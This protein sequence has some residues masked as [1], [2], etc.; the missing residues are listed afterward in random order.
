MCKLKQSCSLS[1]SYPR[2]GCV[3]KDKIDREIG[4]HVENSRL[5]HAIQLNEEEKKAEV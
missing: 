1:N 5:R 2:C 3:L 4:T